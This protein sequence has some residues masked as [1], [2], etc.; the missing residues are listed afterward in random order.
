MCFYLFL[1]LEVLSCLMI[2]IQSEIAL[3]QSILGLYI[4]YYVGKNP[5][6][7]PARRI[8]SLF[9][10]LNCVRT[11]RYLLNTL[12]PKWSYRS[13]DFIPGFYAYRRGLCQ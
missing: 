7:Q 3:L 9:L 4:A 11:F 5:T 6:D 10:R 2:E 8:E 12:G 13:F 1:A